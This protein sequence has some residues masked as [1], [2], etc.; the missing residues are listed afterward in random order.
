MVLLTAFQAGYSRVALVL[1][2]GKLT[3][4]QAEYSRVVLVLSVDKFDSIPS[5]VQPLHQVG[6]SLTPS[7]GRVIRGL[8]GC[9]VLWELDGSENHR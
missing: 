4:F 8:V 1:S 3:A 7:Q 5:W 2:G 6:V 9:M